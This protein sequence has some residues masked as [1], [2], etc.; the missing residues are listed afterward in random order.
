MFQGDFNM[1]VSV[2]WIKKF[3]DIDVSVDEFV[4]KVGAQLGAVEQVI[5]VGAAYQGIVV[6]E[7]MDVA[8]HPDADKLSVCLIDDGGVYDDVARNENGH[9]QVVCGAPNVE[10]GMLAAWLPPK[11]IVPATFDDDEPFVLAS[12]KIRG[13][14]SHGMLASAKELALGDDHSGIIAI[15]VAA[16]PGDDFAEVYELNDYVL[17]IENKMFT[18][19]PDCFGVLGVAREIAGIFGVMFRSPSW[20]RQDVTPEV[21]KHPAASLVIDN[22]AQDIVPR[23]GA[24]VIRDISV[25]DSTL[26]IRSYLSRH[27]VRPINNVVDVTN[28]VML[29]TGQ[30]THAYDAAK[31]QQVSGQDD[32]QLGT[33]RAKAGDELILLDGKK[34]SFD[35][36]EDI[37]LITSHDVPVGVGGVMGGADT[38]VDASTTEIV[39]ECASFDMYAI[40]R[41]SMHLGLFTEAVTRFN[42]GQSPLQ[43]PPVLTEA[44]NMLQH[45]T[46]GLVA[47][48]VVDE[49]DVLPQLP[50]VTV[51]S[52]FVRERLGAAVTAEEIKQLLRNVEFHVSSDSAALHITP[53]WW[54]TDIAIAEDI[55]EEVG[56]LAGFDT[57]PDVL[58]QRPFLPAPRN[59]SFDLKASLRQQLSAA[60]ANEVLTYS[61]VHNKL[62]SAVGQ[63]SEK[64]FCIANALSPDLQFYRMSLTPSLLNKVHMN[65]KAGYR[66]FVLFEMGSVHLKNEYDERD[67]GVPAE[68]QRLSLVV[69]ADEKTWQQRYDGAAYY[70]AS[71]YL[72]DMLASLGINYDLQ[73]MSSVD[74]D[75]DVIH[76]Q[77]SWQQ[78]TAP[79]EPGRSAA[80]S[81]GGS[82]VGIVGEYRSTVRRGLKLPVSSAGFELSLQPLLSQRELKRY[83]PLR[84][85]PAISQDISLRLDASLLHTEIEQTLTQSLR[86]HIES[87]H[88]RPIDVY[89][90][91]DDAS[92]RHV[93]FRVTAWNSER[94]MKNDE[95]SEL[96]ATTATVLEQRYDAR[97]L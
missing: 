38:E 59:E 35:Q 25:T 81:I 61:F 47:S 2:N 36:D 30:P 92:S 83:Q 82:V 20:Y 87:V 17:D 32:L 23:F 62:F 33:R 13:Q 40:R 50:V 3:V 24:I 84:R 72:D 7:V 39:L 16:Q 75:T 88:V 49:Y 89:Q 21:P 4:Q 58:P 43:I 77:H 5:D 65:I 69:A 14:M 28:Y 79:Y 78:M 86:G 10:N 26:L 57:L 11:A 44:T 70:R 54:R 66:D 29:L 74:D 9:I 34:L 85:Y 71:H 93:T 27:G 46:G 42:K 94:T 6:V 18:H 52:T 8:S 60:G 80:I 19:R 73:P 96:L 41:A 68:Y 63:D 90:P 67:T 91:E 56:R 12:R 15:D 76:T 55:V 1:K 64:A 53:P 48:K 97:V 45:A 95:L 22:Q 31:L 51:T 37:V